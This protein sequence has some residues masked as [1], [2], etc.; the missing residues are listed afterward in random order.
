MQVAYV[1]VDYCISMNE[2]NNGRM[3][4]TKKKY[5]RGTTSSMGAVTFSAQ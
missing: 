2:A 3:Q 1:Q 5:K 4:K